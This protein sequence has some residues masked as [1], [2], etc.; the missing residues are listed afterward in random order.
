VIKNDGILLTNS[1]EESFL[2][3]EANM[4]LASQGIPRM[5]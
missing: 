4:S 1:V 5:L 3:S 2:F